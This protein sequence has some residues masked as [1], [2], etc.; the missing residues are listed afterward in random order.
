MLGNYQQYDVE[1]E[2]EQ[3][4]VISCRSWMW[5]RNGDLILCVLEDYSNIDTCGIR[6]C[7]F[8]GRSGI[9]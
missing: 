5:F 1:F 7:R 3:N 4:T 8:D 6:N 9:L 2:L